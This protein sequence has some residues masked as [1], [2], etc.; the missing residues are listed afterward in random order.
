M[1]SKDIV[2]KQKGC[3]CLWIWYGY[4]TIMYLQ[5]PG[6]ML[7][8]WYQ[9][10]GGPSNY[11]SRLCELCHIRTKHFKQQTNFKILPDWTYNNQYG[12]SYQMLHQSGE[13]I[14]FLVLVTTKNVVLVL[15]VQLCLLWPLCLPLDEMRKCGNQI[16]SFMRLFRWE[17]KVSSFC[18]WLCAVC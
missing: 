7:V 9:S 17:V 16:F 12:C 5:S 6:M 13:T 3:L 11:K 10:E 4:V 15:Q 18:S 8:N 14:I 2:L 1:N